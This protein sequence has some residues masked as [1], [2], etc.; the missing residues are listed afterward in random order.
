MLR[1]LAALGLLG[2]PIAFLA[3][4]LIA[5]SRGGRA[6]D[7]MRML[8]VIDRPI[9]VVWGAVADV[10][11]QVEWMAEMKEL[12]LDPPGKAHVGQRGEAAVQILGVSVTDRSRSSASSRRTMPR[13]AT[14]ASSRA[15]A[16][17]TLEPGADGT[18]DPALG[19]DADPAGPA[20]WARSSRRRSC[21]RSSR[22]TSSGSDGW[23]RT[24]R[25]TRP[26]ARA[27]V[28]CS[29]TL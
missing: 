18:D 5:R 21:G 19:R 22:R 23:S 11:F 3:D 2:L 14:S 10:P 27:G 6:P 8:V 25:S 7:P 9:D 26:R 15:A 28:L 24:A 12:V 13:S 17:I 4:W 29:C 16:W 20:G 1:R